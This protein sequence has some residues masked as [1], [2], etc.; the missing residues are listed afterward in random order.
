MPA[1]ASGLAFATTPLEGVNLTITYT[2]NNQTPEFPGPPFSLGQVVQGVD[3]SEYVFVKFA[4][5]YPV[6]TVGF[7]DANW[8]FTALTSANAA[9]VSG[10]LVGVMS[11]VNSLG[12][13]FG[14][15]QTAG[16]SPAI[17]TAA[18]TPANTALFTSATAGQ[19]TSTAAANVAIDGIILTTANGA[20]AGVAPGLLNQPQVLLPS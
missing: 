18:S 2:V 12:G 4:A 1:T 13:D 15:V 16:L 11:Q 6:G 14:F 19:L 5:A 10:Q 7:M 3:N 9:A 17:L 8:N 20:S